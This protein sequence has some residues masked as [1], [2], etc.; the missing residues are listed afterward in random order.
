MKVFSGIPAS[1]G[2]AIGEAFV[3]IDEPPEI[4]R[5][6][7]DESRIG[8]EWA[9]FQKSIGW[10]VEEVKV[11]Y[12]WASRDVSKEQADIFQAH[13]MMLEDVD[14][15][16][17]IK[18]RLENSL[19]NIEWVVWEVSR[20]L[21]Q[22]LSSSPD[23]VFRERA[24]DITDVSRR[25]LDSLLSV[26]QRRF[27]LADLQNDVILVVHDLMPSDLLVMNKS[28]VK[29]LAMDMGSKTCHTAILARSFNIPAVLGLSNLSKEVKDGQ[30][31]ALNGFSGTVVLDPD[32]Q[33]LTQQQ[34][35]EKEYHKQ[36][37]LL[38]SLRELPAQ[39]LDG[40][41][42]TLNANIEFP[43]EVQQVLNYGAEGIGLYRSEFLFL[44]PGRPANEETQY[45]AYSLVLKAMGKLPVTIRTADVGGD[46]AHPE[47][48]PASEKNPLLGCRA[49]R[50]SLAF[51]ELFKTQLRAI[52]RASVHGNV[53]I[54]FPMIS[55]IEEMEQAIALLEETRLECKKNG[56]PF[57]QDIQVGAMIE[58]PSAAMTADILA[59]KSNFFSLGT[60][61]LI[62]YSLAVDRGNEKV[63]YLSDPCHPAVL[64][65]LK[66]TIDAAHEKGI[67]VAMCGELAGDPSATAMLLGLGLDE[68]S[69]TA[70]SI[71]KI[72]QIIRFTT[73]ESC[74][75]LAEQAMAGCSIAEVHALVDAWMANNAKN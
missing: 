65:L 54:M 11:L 5:Y 45:D 23:P 49:I 46:K 16:D 53:R 69:M 35:D 31:L 19:Q 6:S 44:T 21:S 61:D 3:Y 66:R 13:L 17:Q 63:N 30:T 58:I 24:V 48:Q 4:P 15:H 43:E 10:A 39:T 33:T 28:H 52:L 7:I 74:K 25:I 8:A 27:S 64:R 18:D 2:F 71:P 60:N 20:E 29:G 36:A 42:V 22:K 73:I 47:L 9:R 57:A 26:T 40:H 34:D 50:F 41:R 75:A 37:N 56:Q 51:P 55:G 1:S 59:A 62:Q 70:S 68:F 38:D 12:T 72:K 67:K 32:K 14:F